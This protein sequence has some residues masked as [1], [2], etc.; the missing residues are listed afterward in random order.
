MMGRVLLTLGHYCA[1]ATL[2]RGADA[3]AAVGVVLL[4][5]APATG[6]PHG[7]AIGG[8]LVAALS[9]PHVLGPLVARVL[10][11]AP[12]GRV[13]LACSFL[14]YA[15][16]LGICGGL[17]GRVP[18]AV[19]L[20]AAIC[21]G[22]C[23]PLLTGGLSSRLALL[24][25][26]EALRR[27]EAVDSVTYG[28]GSILGPAAVAGLAATAGPRTAVLTVA[29]AA[30]LAG[31]LALAL[32][33]A[34][35]AR[36]AYGGSMSVRAVLALLWRSAPLRRTTVSS[37]LAQTAAGALPVVAALLIVQ[38]GHP[39][40]DAGI[41]VMVDGVGALLG[42]VV[43]TVRQPR[44]APERL[45]PWYI[46]VIAVAYVATALSPSFTVALV[47]FA[48]AG[49]AN[50]PLLAA[51]LSVRSLHAPERGRAQVFVTGAGVKIGGASLGAALAGVA[52]P[53]GGRVVLVLMALIAVSGVAW[54]VVD[55]RRGR[56]ETERDGLSANR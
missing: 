26:P 29:G 50:G 1:A 47:C 9:A 14:A 4:A 41:L 19:P 2:A 38:L 34:A 20:L 49:A 37:T 5:V 53:L 43:V 25:R 13:T 32:P 11:R 16:F 31:L 44:G 24:V 7:P 56:R 28:A 42:S 55:A 36:D 8:L 39:A 10:D 30:A 12:T 22:A 3:A 51:T 35:Q 46:A 33:F 48:V 27:A 54:F 45:I 52:A 18:L 15:V 6:I 17:L 40:S 21:A 23:G